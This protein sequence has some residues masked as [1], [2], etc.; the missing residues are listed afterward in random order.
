MHRIVIAIGGC[1]L[2]TGC[3]GGSG[4]STGDVQV[5]SS[6]AAST[7]PPTP[8]PTPTAAPTPTPT[9]TSTPAPT[10][11][12]T[13][14]SSY[15]R[16]ADLAGDRTFQTACA[17]LVLG[18]G[19]PTPQPALPFG[20]ALALGY[21]ATM[22]GW[23]IAGDGVNLSFAAGDAV[24][25]T[26]GQKIYERAVTGSTQRLT[27]IDPIVSGTT[28]SYTRSLALRADRSSGTTLYSCAFGVPALAADVPTSAASY[29]KVAVTG[30]AYLTDQA[31]AVQAYLLSGSTATVSYNPTA[32]AV[33]V[34]VQL[35]GNL[36]T[37]GNTA[38]TTT[39][40]GTFTSSAAVDSARARFS[41]QLDSANRI[42]LFSSLSGAFFGDTEAGL[43]FEVL[44]TN[45]NNGA[46][47][48]AV[49]TIAASR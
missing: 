41:G 40:L 18:A 16:Y 19:L 22:A 48:V 49:G 34:T 30:T 21:A 26:A 38:S 13:S 43:A 8:T 9:S 32:K 17:S 20:E 11:T 46:R 45:T 1:L 2:L 27:F 12:G 6:T 3:G 28:L 37:A 14:T 29:G 36:Q 31:G 15:Q 4:G 23:T 39:D 42:S 44:A 7:S 24:S 33:V 35:L 5:V 25:A 10:S 47:V